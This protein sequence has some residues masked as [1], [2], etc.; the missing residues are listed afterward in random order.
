MIINN[1]LGDELKVFKWVLLGMLAFILVGCI[2]Y[3]PPNIESVSYT[4]TLSNPNIGYIEFQSKDLLRR[5]SRLSVNIEYTSKTDLYDTKTIHVSNIPNNNGVVQIYVP[6]IDDAKFES[7]DL[8]I[9]YG[10][11][12]VFNTTINTTSEGFKDLKKG[13]PTELSDNGKIITI[14]SE[15]TAS[16]SYSAVMLRQIIK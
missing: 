15:L 9:D 4:S 1:Y 5:T 10:T 16:G 2:K 3:A 8:I 6:K 13:V 14:T 7:V 11:I 12:R